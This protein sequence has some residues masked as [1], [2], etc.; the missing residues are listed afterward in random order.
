MNRKK[1]LDRLRAVFIAVMLAFGLL[2]GGVA[3]S[4]WASP[5]SASCGNQ[6]MAH[7][8]GDHSLPAPDCGNGMMDATCV[9]HVSCTAVMPTLSGSGMHARLTDWLA[10]PPSSLT[11]TR[12]PP[13]TPPPIAL[14]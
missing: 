2:V 5:S 9:A 12:L 4:A 3:D 1:M 13:D 6:A 11:G 14:I 8:S 10:V 7:M